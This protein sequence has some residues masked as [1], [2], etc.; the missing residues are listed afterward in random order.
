MLLRESDNKANASY[1][2]VVKLAE[3]ATGD[4]PEGYRKEFIRLVKSA[5]LLAK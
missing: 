4:D 3:E 5:Q 1:E 2:Q